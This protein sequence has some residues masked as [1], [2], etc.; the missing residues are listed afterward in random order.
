MEGPRHR[1]PHRL[2]SWVAGSAPARRWRWELSD[3]APLPWV[4]AL[5]VIFAVSAPSPPAG[6][7]AAPS[8]AGLV[9]DAELPAWAQE[10]LER[11]E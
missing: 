7:S 10:L 9:G 3:L 4:I 1:A 5:G 6:R 11:G 2:P 8:R